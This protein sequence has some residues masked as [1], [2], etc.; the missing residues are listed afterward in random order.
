[1]HCHKI[2]LESLER[3]LLDK[4]LE[5]ESEDVF[6]ILLAYQKE[7]ETRSIPSYTLRPNTR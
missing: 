3:I 4:F 1:M 7:L 6:V 2:L 5:Q